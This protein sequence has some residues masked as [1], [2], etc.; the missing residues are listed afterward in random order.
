MYIVGLLMCF[1]SI[2]C[3]SAIYKTKKNFPR[4]EPP[5][6]TTSKTQGVP[7][8]PREKEIKKDAPHL[9]ITNSNRSGGQSFPMR[10]VR[11]VGQIGRVGQ[12][13]RVGWV[14]QV[15]QVGPIRQIKQQGQAKRAEHPTNLAKN[16]KNLNQEVI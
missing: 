13:G 16:I 15:G 5:E 8:F 11:L 6:V 4:L 12:V 7:S 3:Q 1:C 9:S 14:G 10:P 2:R